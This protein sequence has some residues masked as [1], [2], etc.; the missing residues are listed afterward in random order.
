MRTVAQCV[1]ELK[2]TDP[3]TVISE[4]YLRGLI[5]QNKIICHQS[6]RRYLVNYDK[7]L[8]FLNQEVSSEVEPLPHNHIR[9]INA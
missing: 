2:K 9:A 4:H 7:L 5:H 3:Q 1:N 8:A 6:G